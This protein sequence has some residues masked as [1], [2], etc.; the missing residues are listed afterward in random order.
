MKLIQLTEHNIRKCN[1]F[2]LSDKLLIGLSGGID[3]VVLLDILIKL[4]YE[5][6]AV[7]CNFRLRGDESDRDELFVRSWCESVGVSLHVEHFDTIEYAERNN[8]SIE[9]AARELRYDLFARL[10]NEK[11]LDRIVVAHHKDDNVETI[12]IN[13][14]RGTGIRGLTGIKPINGLVVRPLLFASRDEIEAYASENGLSSVFDST[15][16]ENLYVRNKIRNQIIPLLKELNPSFSDSIIRS[17]ENLEGCLSIYNHEIERLRK[18]ILSP[19]KDGYTLSI[20]SILNYVEPFTLLYELLSPYGFNRVV[21]H[22]L[23][24]TLD[25]Q[26]GKIFE[27]NEYRLEKGRTELILF[28]KKRD[29]EESFTLDISTS[30]SLDTSHFTIRWSVK[31]DLSI[32]SIKK[33]SQVAYIDSSKLKT[34]LIIR[35]WKRG[36]YYYP[37]GMKGKKKISDWFANNKMNLSQKENTWLLCSDDQLVWIVGHRVDR[38]FIADE[39]SPDGVLFEVRFP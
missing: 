14:I 33:T 3:S 2:S 16:A 4:G 13:L 23:Y 5:C 32:D 36:D 8:L 22:D 25:G 30:G 27:S 20:E 37:T 10:M 7:H 15:N 31:N 17:I 35:R 28:P 18:S 12:L 38:R 21:I 24:R 19:Y 34:P 1:L 26:A 6:V 11:G 9:M 39:H 29:K